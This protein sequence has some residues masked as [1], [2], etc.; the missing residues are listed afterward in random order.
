[1]R[2]VSG[3]CSGE[4]S[5]PVGADCETA[6]EGFAANIPY[7]IRDDSDCAL[8]VVASVAPPVSVACWIVV[9]LDGGV[10]VAGNSS[11]ILGVPPRPETL[12]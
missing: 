4:T 7:R 8:Y 6:L 11:Q 3:V 5:G 2:G 9:C 10:S 12:V 1:M